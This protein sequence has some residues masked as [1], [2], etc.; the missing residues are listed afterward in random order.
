MFYSSMV[1]AGATGGGGLS[2]S[3]L[4][5]FVC[6]SGLEKYNGHTVPFN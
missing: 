3:L 1:W 5:F 6:T 4:T 2:T